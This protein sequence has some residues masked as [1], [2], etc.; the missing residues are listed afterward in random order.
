MAR[1]FQRTA[2]IIR[3]PGGFQKKKISL[4]FLPVPEEALIVE[5]KAGKNF[6]LGGYIG[7]IPDKVV[8]ENI[9][10]SCYNPL[11]LQKIRRTTG[12][13]LDCP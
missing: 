5:K 13:G 4:F 6:C 7:E 11:I 3:N 1:N 8:Q 12:I 2:D 9:D 10:E